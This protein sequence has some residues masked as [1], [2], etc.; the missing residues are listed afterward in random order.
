LF[1]VNE[2]AGTKTTR[3]DDIRPGSR[4][5]APGF[6]PLDTGATR[7]LVAFTTLCC[8]LGTAHAAQ[9]AVQRFDFGGEAAP[10]FTAV[11]ADTS[12]TPERG[13]GF[14]LGSRPETVV[15]QNADPAR[16][17]HCTG[18]Q[19]FYFSVAVPEGNHRVLVTFGDRNTGSDN[20]LKAESRRLMLERVVTRAGDFATRTVIVNTRGPQLSSGAKVGLKPREAGPPLV[21][22]WDDKLTLEFNGPRPALCTLEIAPAPDLPT[23]FLAGDSTVTD[24]A[25]EPW[26]SWGQM[27]TRFFGPGIAVANHAESGETLRGSYRARRIAKILDSM[28]AGD[29]LLVQFGHNDMKDKSPGAL[30]DYKEHLRRIVRE[31][32]AKQ[33][34]PLLVTPVE[35][36]AGVKSDTLAGYP[37]AVREIAREQEADCL[38]LHA[39]SKQLYAALGDHLRAAFQDGSHHNAYGSYEIARCIAAALREKKH[40]LAALLAPDLVPFDPVR[41]DPPESF[42]IPPSP[43]RGDTKP[44][45]S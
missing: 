31:T 28:R 16:D 41:P 7:A 11:A 6:R 26:N 35:R 32:R 38:D 5:R 4:R 12:Y 27:L 30:D 10:G 21:L 3:R 23:L 9:P 15:R 24:Q 1:A 42:R 43:Q 20:T 18:N 34:T 2:M 14:D 19:P 29:Y 8:G 36:M 45:G 25:L 17:G 37:D 40:P 44:D 39:L 13:H 33:A 22:H